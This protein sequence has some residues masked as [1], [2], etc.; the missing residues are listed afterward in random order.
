MRQIRQDVFETNSSSTH[1]I[2]ISKEPV[3][4]IPK[5][6]YIFTLMNLDGSPCVLMTQR[7]ICIQL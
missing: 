4:V 7:V 1:S 3:N 2:C 5:K 6:K